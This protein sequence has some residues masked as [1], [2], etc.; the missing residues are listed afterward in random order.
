ML[1]AKGIFSGLYWNQPLCLPI[2]MSICVQNTNTQ[3]TDGIATL[4]NSPD[5]K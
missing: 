1:L 5:F 3:S 2:G 4:P